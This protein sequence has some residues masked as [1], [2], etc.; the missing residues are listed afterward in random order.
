V[1]GC[2]FFENAG[3]V[4]V[5]GEQAT[6]RYRRGRYELSGNY[7]QTRSLD[8]SSLDDENGNPIPKHRIAYIAPNRANAGADIDW[9]DRVRT[10]VRAHYVAART[11]DSVTVGAYATADAVFGYRLKSGNTALQVILQNISGRAY[12]APSPV[13][14]VPQKG[15]ALYLRLIY[16]GAAQ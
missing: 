11:S 8:I 3:A 15:R 12:F 13:G 9:T 6:G 14:G 2:D 4:D 1:S 16:G 5:R 10:S 7:T